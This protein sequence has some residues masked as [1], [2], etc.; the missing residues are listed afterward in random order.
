VIQPGMGYWIEVL[1]GHPPV[2]W[3]FPVPKTQP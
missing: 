3:V 2:T 1:Q